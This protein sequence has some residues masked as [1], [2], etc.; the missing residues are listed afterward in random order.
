MHEVGPNI[1]QCTKSIAGECETRT[2]KR[3][4]YSVNVWYL[5]LPYL[6]YT[7]ATALAPHHSDTIE[8]ALR[9]ITISI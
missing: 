9:K 3:F 7:V 5:G 4:A 6:S 2:T 1:D 8:D